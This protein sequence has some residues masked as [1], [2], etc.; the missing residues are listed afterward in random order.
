[1]VEQEK[2]PAVLRPVFEKITAITDDGILV[3]RGIIPFVPSRA[4]NVT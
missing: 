1:M 2:V 4:G 3:E